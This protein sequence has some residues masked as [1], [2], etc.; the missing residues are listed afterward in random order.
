VALWLGA[1]VRV[2]TLLTVLRLRGPLRGR[3][4]VLLL[5]RSAWRRLESLWGLA[6]ELRRMA[7]GALAQSDSY[8]ASAIRANG[9]RSSSQALEN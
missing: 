3:V 7:V 9:H 2:R 5:G 6:A 1:V 4:A 8:G